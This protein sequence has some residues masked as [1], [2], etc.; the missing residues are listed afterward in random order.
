MGGGEYESDPFP[1]Y[2]LIREIFHAPEKDLAK[3]LLGIC[4]FVAVS[5][6]IPAVGKGVGALTLCAI[7]YLVF[8]ALA[9]YCAFNVRRTTLWGASTAVAGLSWIPW[10]GFCSFISGIDAPLTALKLLGAVAIGTLV[11]LISFISILSVFMIIR[12]ITGKA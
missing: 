12:L 6:L 1:A 10:V 11:Q 7:H 2:S 9:F 5:L 4:G 8:A 3:I